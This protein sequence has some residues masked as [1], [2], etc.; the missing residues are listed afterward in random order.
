VRATADLSRAPAVGERATLHVEFLSQRAGRLTVELDA[1]GSFAWTRRPAGTTTQRHRSTAPDEGGCVDRASGT[2]TVAAGRPL[3]LTGELVA[4]ATGFAAIRV[5]AT[6]VRDG[7]GEDAVY[8]TVGDAPS[9]S[10]FGYR[11]DSNSAASTAAAG[12]TTAAAC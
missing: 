7:A 12:A 4:R 9:S 2:W 6:G 5:R 10:H 11:G 1:P 8:V 3:R